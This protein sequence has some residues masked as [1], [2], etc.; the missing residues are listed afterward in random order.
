MSGAMPLLPTFIRDLRR[1]SPYIHVHS[2]P[3]KIFKAEFKNKKK[4]VVKRDLRFLET[5]TDKW[6]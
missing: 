5:I 3:I 6:T 2:S 4:H 1:N